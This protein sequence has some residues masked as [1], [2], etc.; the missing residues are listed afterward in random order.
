MNLDPFFPARRV[1]GTTVQ[2]SNVLNTGTAVPNS[3]T[4]RFGVLVRFACLF[5][6]GV[7][8]C[9][10]VATQ[11]AP[12]DV[13]SPIPTTAATLPTVPTLSIPSGWQTVTS[14]QQCGFN[15]S[16]PAEMKGVS[17]D[18]YSWLI[19]T[20]ATDPDQVAPNFVYVTAVPTD[21]QNGTEIAYN[22]DSAV[23]DLLM[24]MQVGAAQPV[25]TNPD[26]ATWFT[27]TR[28][29]DIT[30]DGQ[31]AQAYEN[32]QPWEFPAG[33]KEIRYYLKANDCIYQLGG[34]MDTTGST[35]PGAID[36]DLVNQIVATFQLKP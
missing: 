3:Q 23:T 31:V 22:Y 8:G 36:E 34:Y 21:F 33:T 29:P 6:L 27:F 1:R 20:A 5:L 30:I 4:S 26:M 2:E 28:L 24:N 12:T 25:H 35:Q 10:P 14:E 32:T 17:Q 7:V 18:S 15:I 16:H 9:V 13:P 11:T 19:S